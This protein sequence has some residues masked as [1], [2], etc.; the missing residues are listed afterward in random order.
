MTF[1]GTISNRVLHRK[2]Q[3]ELHAEK[4]KGL[5]RVVDFGDNM[6]TFLFTV[7]TDAVCTTPLVEFKLTTAK[8][9]KHKIIRHTIKKRTKCVQIISVDDF[10]KTA[11][12]N[13]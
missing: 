2:L 8:L 3:V 1:H 11:F 4:T 12:S 10:L 5:A 13:G 6:E 9:R 7:E